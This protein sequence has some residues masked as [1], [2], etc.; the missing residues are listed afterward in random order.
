MELIE[1]NI[2]FSGDLEF[3]I[4]KTYRKIS[5]TR[6][7]Y[8]AILIVQFNGAHG[9]G[10]GGNTNSNFMRTVVAAAMGL[11]FFNGF[12]LDLTG[13]EYSFGDS[14]FSVIELPKKI[15]G[16]DLLYRIIVSE[17]CEKGLLSLLDY[18]RV[19]NDFFTVKAL[20]IGAREI[21]KTLATG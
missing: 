9:H 14:L 6:Y 10:S 5:T 1:Q 18:M 17:K 13:L 21:F 4:Q 19:R 2:I 8:D 3:R 16:E 7:D 15:R 11:N 20:D 12:I